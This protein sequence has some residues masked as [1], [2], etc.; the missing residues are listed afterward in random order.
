L[1]PCG[2]SPSCADRSSA[3]SPRAQP[4]QLWRASPVAGGH[5]GPFS[6]HPGPHRGFRNRNPDPEAFTARSIGHH[7][8]KTCPGRST[9]AP[10]L[11]VAPRASGQTSVAARTTTPPAN[12]TNANK[13]VLTA[14]S[15]LEFR[16]LA[17]GET[18]R[19]EVSPRQL[20]MGRTPGC[21]KANL[22]RVK[23]CP[24]RSTRRF[25]SSH[26]RS[27]SVW[28]STSLGLR[29]ARSSIDQTTVRER[30]ILPPNRC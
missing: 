26:D 14:A 21:R 18:P 22:S 20:P 9:C 19:L 27:P 7:A 16:R 12:K 29:R 13:G 24:R 30:N 8:L 10:A 5:S 25:A 2:T 28:L 6:P 23:T 3:R 4:R 1:P 17:T 11:S 15:C